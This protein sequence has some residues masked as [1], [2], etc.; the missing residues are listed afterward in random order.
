MEPEGKPK[1]E[2]QTKLQLD[3]G[4]KAR[5]KKA[6]DNGAVG[7]PATLATIL[8]KEAL[9]HYE[10]NNYKFI[11]FDELHLQERDELPNGLGDSVQQR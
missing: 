4:W 3:A 10:A 11:N 2:P 1:R 7:R 6:A 9:R 5:L 8:F